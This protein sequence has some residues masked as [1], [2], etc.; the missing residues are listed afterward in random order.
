MLKLSW[1]NRSNVSSVSSVYLCVS[2][3]TLWRTLSLSSTSRHQTTWMRSSQSSPRPSWTPVPL[4]SI[5]WVGWVEAWS[6]LQFKEDKM[7]WHW[8]KTWSSP[9]YFLLFLVLMSFCFLGQDS[10]INKLLYARDIPRYKQM[11]ERWAHVS[12]VLFETGSKIAPWTMELGFVL[13]TQ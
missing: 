12:S 9:L 2:G 4:L 6:I 11:V 5:S 1:N 7:S 8:N 10:P 3:S 13:C